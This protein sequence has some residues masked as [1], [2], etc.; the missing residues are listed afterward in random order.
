[1]HNDLR[2][3]F[4]QSCDK[5][6]EVFLIMWLQWI[7]LTYSKTDL[8]SLECAKILYLIIGPTLLESG[9]EVRFIKCDCIIFT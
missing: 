7:L 6:L 5:S 3:Y 8:I 9:A 4:C 2:K 1:M